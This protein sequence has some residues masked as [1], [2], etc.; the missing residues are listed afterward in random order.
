MNWTKLLESLC[1][2]SKTT[3][4]GLTPEKIKTALLTGRYCREVTEH[5]YLVRESL[6]VFPGEP[7]SDTYK[8]IRTICLLN[9]DN[10]SPVNFREE[11]WKTVYDPYTQ[12][13]RGV[14]YPKLYF[15]LPEEDLLIAGTCLYKKIPGTLPEDEF[16]ERIKSYLA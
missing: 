4:I 14:G 7:N 3:T 15:F 8:I 1:T 6:T 12:E 9:P 2:Y 13:L 10:Q 5:G 11:E 16:V